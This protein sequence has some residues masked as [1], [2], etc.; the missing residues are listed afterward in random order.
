MGQL[1]LRGNVQVFEEQPNGQLIPKG[2]IPLEEANDLVANGLALSREV[3]GQP[4]VIVKPPKEEVKEIEVIGE[5]GQPQEIPVEIVEKRRPRQKVKIKEDVEVN[6]LL[7]RS[8]LRKHAPYNE[9][10]TSTSI[11]TSTNESPT[12]I[13]AIKSRVRYVFEPILSN[14][15][16]EDTRRK[17]VYKPRYAVKERAILKPKDFNIYVSD[18]DYE[19]YLTQ[20]V[21]EDYAPKDRGAITY[22]PQVYQQSYPVFNY[23]SF[24]IPETH[25]DDYA[26]HES[27]KINPITEFEINAKPTPII[28]SQT[29]FSLLNWLLS[30]VMR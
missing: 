24:G 8:L 29:Y 13:D 12:F 21:A 7:R 26:P 28:V 1:I 23:S 20:I 11:I 4:A 16:Y 17:T 14:T 19:P 15:T 27:V 5:P 2:V 18:D 30:G 6:P 25:V 9:N 22:N 10:E 3:N